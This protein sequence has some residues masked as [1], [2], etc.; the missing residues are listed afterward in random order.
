MNQW[1]ADEYDDPDRRV[2]KDGPRV[3]KGGAWSFG[4]HGALVLNRDRDLPDF[5]DYHDH[6]FRV[7]RTR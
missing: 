7:C 6:G 4:M 5:R 1:C 2:G 3:L